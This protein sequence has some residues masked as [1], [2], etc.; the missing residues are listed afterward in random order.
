CMGKAANWAQAFW[1]ERWD[2]D[3]N[4]CP[5]R[6][7]TELEPLKLKALAADIDTLAGKQ[8]ANNLNRFLQSCERLV[9]R[10]P[11]KVFDDSLPARSK[12]QSKPPARNF[13]QR[14]G[15]HRD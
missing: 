7:K 11:V 3:W 9:V 4:I 14:C 8:Q 15:A 6:L 5:H 10:D 13:I 1:C 12:A 2:I